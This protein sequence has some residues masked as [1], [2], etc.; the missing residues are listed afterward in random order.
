MMDSLL[1]WIGNGFLAAAVVLG[2]I[3]FICLI[4][5]IAGPTLADRA[6]ALDTINTLVVATMVLLS[7][8]FR[9]II[10]VDVAIVYA[11]LSW[12][13]TLYFANYLEGGVE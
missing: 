12:I 3:M 1:D 5:L 2:L 8:A 4:R 7:A 11:F 10:Y 13:T 6:V 9:E